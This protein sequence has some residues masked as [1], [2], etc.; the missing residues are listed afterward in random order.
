MCVAISKFAPSK[1]VNKGR[2]FFFLLKCSD[3]GNTFKPAI[4]SSTKSYKTRKAIKT[5]A[6]KGDNSFFFFQIMKRR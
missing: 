1:D 4:L 6:K 2:I 5:F 3:L